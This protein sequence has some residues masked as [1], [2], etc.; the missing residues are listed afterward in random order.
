LDGNPIYLEKRL[1][2]INAKKQGTHGAVKDALDDAGQLN[3][4]HFTLLTQN[5]VKTMAIIRSNRL[6]L[7]EN[8]RR[9]DLIPNRWVQIEYDVGSV[10]IS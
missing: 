8:S 10:L 4:R 5:G 7:D 1:I 6:H 3:P 2:C 9:K